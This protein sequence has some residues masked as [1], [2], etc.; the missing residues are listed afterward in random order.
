MVI[1]RVKKCSF[2]IY[3]ELLKDL[4]GTLNVSSLFTI[5]CFSQKNFEYCKEKI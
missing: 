4:L 1:V 2:E 3:L 5:F